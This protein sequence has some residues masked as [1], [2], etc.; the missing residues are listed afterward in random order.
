MKK[1]NRIAML[2][3]TCVLAI[4]SL[5]IFFLTATE[6]NFVN[7]TVP[8]EIQNSE[9]VG[10]SYFETTVEI[11]RKGYYFFNI[12]FWP[13]FDPGFITGFTVKDEAGESV[14]TVTGNKLTMDSKEIKLSAGI[15][16]VRADFLANDE[17]YMEYVKNNGFDEIDCDFEG[18]CDGTW[19]MVYDVSI[20]RSLKGLLFLLVLAIVSFG[21]VFGT[22]VTSAF[23]KS[24]KIMGTY[25]ERQLVARYKSGFVAFFVVLF[26]LAIWM[27]ASISG[28]SVP[29]K[30][31]VIILS[32]IMIGITVMAINGILHDGYYGLDQDKKAFQI[33]FTILAV[34]NLTIGIV[35]I[36]NGRVIVNGVLSVNVLSLEMGIELFAIVATSYIKEKKDNE[37]EEE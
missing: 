28:V 2:L 16:T 13:D 4:S 8:V 31:T 32:I 3:L 25:D 24:E 1:G 17:Q 19:S 37:A 26:L 36:A 34:I 29:A 27:V 23:T 5:G 6:E 14:L 33:F 35:S 15:Y 9:V 12:D 20:N 10:E 18:F 22:M 11:G 30:D 21:A 7:F